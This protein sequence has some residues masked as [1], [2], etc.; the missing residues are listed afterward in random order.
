MKK[1]LVLLSGG[2]DSAA[3]VHWANEKGYDVSTLNFNLGDSKSKARVHAAESISKRITDSA[4]YVD[5]KT[6][7]NISPSVLVTLAADYALKI[8]ADKLFYGIHK[9]DTVN[10][11]GISYF[12]NTLSETISLKAG[13]N[14]HVEAPFLYY[15]QSEVLN[16][17]EYLDTDFSETWS[18]K[19]RTD[20]HCGYCD[21]CVERIKH[22]SEAGVTD[23]TNYHLEKTLF[24]Y[25]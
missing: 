3:L 15:S 11:E 20:S 8:N 12:N 10:K 1:A 9:N 4:Y 21:S 24:F 19:N 5:L 13:K 6:T 23:D 18:C 16:L 17:G 25:R 22:F 2:P 7:K 14:F